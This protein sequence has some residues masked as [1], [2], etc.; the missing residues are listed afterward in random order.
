MADPKKKSTP[1]ARLKA[2]SAKHQDKKRLAAKAKSLKAAAI[3]KKSTRAKTKAARAKRQSAQNMTTTE[4]LL[5]FWIQSI[6]K[7]RKSRRRKG[8]GSDA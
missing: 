4:R 1:Y 6:K 2:A 8:G 3:A 5:P 7:S